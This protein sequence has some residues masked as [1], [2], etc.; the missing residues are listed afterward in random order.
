MTRLVVVG[1]IVVDADSV[2]NAW[3]TKKRVFYFITGDAYY[4]NI[5]VKSKFFPIRGKVSYSYSYAIG[6]L[7]KLE[8]PEVKV[9]EKIP[10]LE[11]ASDEKV[12]EEISDPADKIWT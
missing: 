6:E 2:E 11:K 4:L 7:Q 1:D 8:K 10:V 9:P 5:K 3:L 12:A